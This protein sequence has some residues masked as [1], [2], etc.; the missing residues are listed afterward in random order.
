[1]REQSGHKVRVAMTLVAT[2]T[3]VLAAGGWQPLAVAATGP[4]AAGKTILRGWGT[5]DDGA[6]GNGSGALNV[7]APM[8]VKVPKGV[9]IGSVR[10]GCDHS[11][12]VTSAGSVLAWGDNTEGQVGDGTT[13][14][15]KVPA[16]VKLPKGTKVTAARAG[17]DHSLALTKSGAVLAWGLNLFGQ[18]GDGTK[19]NRDA[20]VKVKLPKGTKIK[21]ISAGCDDGFALS[22]TGKLYAW[23]L[24][25][26]GQLGDGTKKN[27]K[28]PVVIKF[29]AGTKITAITAGCTHTLALTTAGLWGWGLNS[30]GQLGTG[31][32]KSTDV[33]VAIFFLFRGQGP[34]K[35]I[36]IFAGCFQTIALFSKGA[37]LA[38]GANNVGQLGNGSSAPNS[39]KPVGVMLPA[40]IKVKAISAGCY[41]GY[42]LTST[43]QVYA[44]GINTS[45][46]LGNGSTSPD[47]NVPVLVHLPTASPA[48]AIGSGPAAL[49]AFA[50]SP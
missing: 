19:K 11:V 14:T 10:A 49:H 46:E 37:V 30:A 21:A 29:P 15:R 39:V 26:D 34:G 7:L 44:W 1:M 17:C 24:N 22:T 32:M 36:S 18:L 6:I 40:N 48:V 3:V 31:D 4:A 25:N 42:A 45:G 23:G 50:I 27:R 12:A 47:I 33:P 9:V 43:G 41:N 35:I 5:N 20:P 38:W 13:K 8:R 16:A 2:A 28:N